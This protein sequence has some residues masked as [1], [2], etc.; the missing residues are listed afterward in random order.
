[1]TEENPVL[2]DV[3]DSVG[4]ITLNR[5]SR[6]NA[7]SRS[8]ATSL[9]ESLAALEDNPDARAIVIIGA[10]DRAFCAGAD[11][12]ERASMSDLDVRHFLT[13]LGG[14][15]ESIER[16]GTPVIAAINGFALG[17][18]L[19][20]ALA[21][22]IRLASKTASMGLTE[23]RLAIIPGGGGT[24]RLPRIVGL[25]RA[26]EMILT[27]RRVGA[28]EAERIGLILEACEPDALLDRAKAIAGEIAKGG[29]LA[30]AQAK[31]AVHFGMQTDLRT[32]LAI[33]RKAYET[34]LPTTDRIEA[35]MAFREKRSPNFE[36]K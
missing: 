18:G 30:I 10:G 6:M 29:P 19:E 36:G 23:V 28:E 33:E 16:M 4:V 22:D 2:V 14:M 25:A 21:C 32:G 1:M 34:L 8:L 24:Q 27:G 12:K 13:N 31:F 15:L 9:F 20:L 7:V 3:A 35:L 5:S 11:L 26:K 17:G